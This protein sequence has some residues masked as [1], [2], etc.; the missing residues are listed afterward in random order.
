MAAT[1]YHKSNFIQQRN[2]PHHEKEHVK[3]S[4]TRDRVYNRINLSTK[5]T[6]KVHQCNKGIHNKILRS[7]IRY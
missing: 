4:N 5:V 3:I 1:N 7:P 2:E 6:T